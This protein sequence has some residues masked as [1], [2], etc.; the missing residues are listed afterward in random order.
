M[1]LLKETEDD[2]FYTDERLQDTITINGK[3]YTYELHTSKKEEWKCWWF[4][5]YA[6]F[7]NNNLMPPEVRQ[8]NGDICFL[9]S[10]SPFSA[11]E[12]I[13]DINERIS[14][15]KVPMKKPD[16]VILIP[17]GN[18]FEIP[19]VTSYAHGCNCIGAMGKGIA[20][21]FRNKYPEMYA[22]YHRMCKNN[23]YRPGDCYAYNHGNGYVFNLA[24]Q[25]DLRGA[26][27]T[28]I[29]KSLKNMFMK[30]DGAGI[31]DIAMPAIGAGL[32]KLNWE[33]IKE[34]IFEVAADYP[35]V[36]LHVVEK[37]KP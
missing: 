36:R 35:N 12:C 31:K 16:N 8:K 28:F 3:Q 14:N 15:I 34:Y 20:V 13:A 2:V 27:Y 1:I 7:A 21:Q 11:T 5:V 4:C 32:G 22:T 26:S 29:K 6:D 18:I 33:Y 9:A 17:E 37:Y 24:T 25:Y 30:A 10:S 23:Q 19:G